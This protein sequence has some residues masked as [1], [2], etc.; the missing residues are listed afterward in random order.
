M[1]NRYVYEIRG[2]A[3]KEII[4]FCK[5]YCIMIINTDHYMTKFVSDQNRLR[6]L[7]DHFFDGL[8]FKLRKW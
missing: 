4:D 8:E 7:H 2:K 3:D 1:N 6:M 5:G